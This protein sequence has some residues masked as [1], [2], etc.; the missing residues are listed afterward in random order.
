M[1][2]PTALP[3]GLSKLALIFIIR[4]RLA[5]FAII[6]GIVG[7][8]GG[9]GLRAMSTASYSRPCSTTRS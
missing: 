8:G 5:I 1:G 6:L 2:V 3:L 7:P 4:Y 9:G